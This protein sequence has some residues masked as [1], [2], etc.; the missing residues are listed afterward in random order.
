MNISVF[1][2]GYVGVVTAACLADWGHRV[3]GVDKVTE[4]VGLINRG[5]SPI[6]EDGLAELVSKGVNAGR[7]SAT[8]DAEN[9]IRDS[10]IAFVCVGTPSTSDGALDSLHVE[11]VVQEIGAASE[12]RDGDLLVVIRSTVLP[13]TVRGKLAPLLHKSGGRQIGNGLDIVFHPEFLRE[14]R[15]IEDFLGPSMIVVGS[16]K[17]HSSDRLLSLYD[18]IKAP[19]F[20]TSL[21]VAEMVK[22]ACNAFHAVKVTFA[23]E[24]GQFCK[25]R[26]IDSREV[27]DIF[28]G[29]TFLNISSRYLRP[30]FA[31]GG[32][33]LPTDIRALLRCAAARAN[34]LPM[35]ESILT[36]NS[37][38]INR[39]VEH[40]LERDCR[41]VGIFGLA[42]KP[43][44]DDLRES[45][46]VAVVE[47]LLR[48]GVKISI[49][50]DEVR[51]AR[52]L[53]KNRSFIDQHLPHLA[54]LLV[55]EVSAL[56]NAELVLINHPTDDHMIAGFLDR[57]IA[58]LDMT[59]ESRFPG[60]EGYETIV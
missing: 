3:I 25:S 34:S 8:E 40:I 28:C 49:Y 46:H 56:R 58:V 42:F 12:A 50:D 44:T 54:D 29:D 35:L 4:K 9:A 20:A 21:E 43:D 38:Q 18:G 22:Y 30:G 39:A 37:N 26:D 27:M 19:R 59:G 2:L 53:G 45:P 33:C 52:I 6:V 13:G 41:Q 15:S 60:R 5:E 57:G 51:L 31:F 32:S 47:R 55:E 16:S 23:N 36:S 14:G 11:S 1:G 10:E 24:I 17:Q 48:E 7:L